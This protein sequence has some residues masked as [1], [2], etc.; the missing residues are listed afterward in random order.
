MVPLTSHPSH[1]RDQCDRVFSDKFENLTPTE[2]KVEWE[3]RKAREKRKE[4][5]GNL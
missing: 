1:S 3:R 5:C 2:E 4:S